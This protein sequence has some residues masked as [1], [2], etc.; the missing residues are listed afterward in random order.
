MCKIEILPGS[1]ETT[2]KDASQEHMIP[3]PQST[4]DADHR[5]PASNPVDRADPA[6]GPVMANTAEPRYQNVRVLNS[7]FKHIFI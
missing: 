1:K 2:R 3:G 7:R 4:H 5:A 6:T